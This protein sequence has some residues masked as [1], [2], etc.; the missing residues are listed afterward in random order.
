VTAALFVGER[1]A[2]LIDQDFTGGVQVL[3][4]R[5]A[6]VAARQRALAVEAH[7]DD[8]L[9]MIVGLNHRALVGQRGAL[10]VVDLFGAVVT[11]DDSVDDVL[12]I[13]SAERGRHTT[14]LAPKWR[15]R[16][17]AF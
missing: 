5:V 2:D 17:G 9:E 12:Q 4:Q 11:F 10:Q 6:Q 14:S 13:T 15:L 16:R 8:G 3:A 7:V 1:A